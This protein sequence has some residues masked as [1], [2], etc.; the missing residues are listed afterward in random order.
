LRLALYD[1]R[2]PVYEKTLEYIDFV[3]KN[4]TTT[5]EATSA[6]RRDVVAKKF[7]FKEDV[8]DFVQKLYD[9]GV[10]LWSTAETL[11]GV[12]FGGGITEES[13]VQ[14]I[15]E[16]GELKK[17]FINQEEV[18]KAVFLRYLSIPRSLWL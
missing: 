6:F 5:A 4:G 14:M 17:W 9:N 1:K 7:L 10:N 15:L 11:K 12:E 16:V 8:Q 18:A 2:F 3:H 13:R